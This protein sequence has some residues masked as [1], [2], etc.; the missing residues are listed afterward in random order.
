MTS[1]TLSSFRPV[2]LNKTSQEDCPFCLVV[3]GKTPIHKIYEDEKTIAF[4]DI[5]PIRKGHTLI[6]PK[7]HFDNLSALNDGYEESMMKTL[8]LVSKALGMT[9]GDDR[10]QVITNQG[11]A[12][13]VPHLHFHIVPAPP[14]PG[15]GSQPV[16]KPP[17]TKSKPLMSL[18]GHGREE[19][20]DEDGANLAKTVSTAVH[21]IIAS[22]GRSN[23][24][25]L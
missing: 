5:L 10:L 3:A 14:L 24:A 15:S 22:Q 16:S 20:D 4:L 12:Q 23:N 21:D 19:L 6:V 7:K 9:L 8:V 18:L 13:V 2:E 17:K 25:K 1:H 11:Y